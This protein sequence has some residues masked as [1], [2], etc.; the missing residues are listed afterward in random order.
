MKPTVRFR[1]K[2]E[3]AHHFRTH[4]ALAWRHEPKIVLQSRHNISRLLILFG[5]FRNLRVVTG[6]QS[7]SDLLLGKLKQARL[8][9][10]YLVLRQ[11]RASVQMILEFSSEATRLLSSPA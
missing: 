11:R 7:R 6:V 8:S 4:G 3:L 5:E 10:F 1:G 2:A 9:F